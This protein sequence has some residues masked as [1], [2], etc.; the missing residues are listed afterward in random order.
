MRGF[1]ALLVLFLLPV[2]GSAQSATDHLLRAVVE[3]NAPMVRHWLAQ[4]GDPNFRVLPTLLTMASE[5]GQVEVVRLLL[6]G[7]ARIDTKDDKTRTALMYAA[8]NGHADVVRVLL[9]K[10]ANPNARND[11]PREY[12]RL[13]GSSPHTYKDNQVSALMY[14]AGGG[15]T[16]VVSILIAAGARVNAKA[17][18][19]ETALMFAAAKGHTGTV[20]KLL[21]LGANLHA[22]AEAMRQNAARLGIGSGGTALVYAL[23]AKHVDTAKAL[24]DEYVRRREPVGDG[25]TVFMYALLARDLEIVTTLADQ[26]GI[27]SRQSSYLSLAAR[28]S[29]AEIVKFLR[30]RQRP[31]DV[32]V[33]PIDAEVLTSAA[34]SGDLAKVKLLVEGGANVNGRARS[35]QNALYYAVYQGAED[36]SAY[37]I[38]KGIEVNVVGDISLG[39]S[40]MGDTA[41]AMAVQKGRVKVVGQ[42]LA[43]G[44]DIHLK[45]S[46]GKSAVQVANEL[47]RNDILLLF[48]AAG[49]IPVDALPI[50]VRGKTLYRQPAVVERELLRRS[51]EKLYAAHCVECHRA[52][53]AGID[54]QRSLRQSRLAGKPKASL[55]GALLRGIKQGDFALME[56]HESRLLDVEAAALLSYIAE[57]WGNNL[58]LSFQPQDIAVAR[59][60]Q[61]AQVHEPLVGNEAP[62]AIA[63]LAKLGYLYTASLFVD[64]VRHND[65]EAVKLFLSAGM[66][67]A[68]ADARG[69]TTLYVSAV[70]DNADILELLLDRGA[71]PYMRNRPWAGGLTAPFAAVTGPNCGSKSRALRLMLDRGLDPNSKQGGRTLLMTAVSGNC[72]DATQLL[73]ER[74]ADVNVEDGGWT[75]LRLAKTYG[76][77]SLVQALVNA[78]ATK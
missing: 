25:D 30:D 48:A 74:R 55:I 78:G 33:G 10:G 76:R 42:L 66:D 23:R 13:H 64:A 34:D 71:D 29:T 22:N 28:G 3:G 26:K 47:G 37:L 70:A 15:H 31:Q 45:R 60:G 24:V 38:N 65:R 32:S 11:Y 7:G 44:A 14:A 46:D 21:E 6:D 4:G 36:V 62:T 58:G 50:H 1:V 56:E 69:L 63:R 59:S 72:S 40:N 52:D 5:K 43:A 16:E 49:R 77:A 12:F 18:Y 73:I 67:P 8:K 57:A 61:P 19:E 54:S 51:G 17:Y 27:D 53:G 20:Q 68:A 2:Q 75:A 39:W 35:G 41:L 9:S